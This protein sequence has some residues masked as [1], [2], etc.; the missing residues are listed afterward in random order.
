MIMSALSVKP[1]GELSHDPDLPGSL[2][3]NHISGMEG[4]KSR[5][6]NLNTADFCLDFEGKSNS[7]STISLISSISFSVILPMS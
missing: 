6:P 5:K 2:Q 3:L 4:E 1:A 7:F